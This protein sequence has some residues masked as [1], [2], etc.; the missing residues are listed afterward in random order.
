M[1]PI[2]SPFQ[3]AFLAF[4][5]N[6]SMNLMSSGIAPV[7]IARQPHHLPG[8]PGDRQL[9]GALHAAVRIAADRARRAAKRRQ[10]AG[11]Q[12]LGRRVLGIRMG[13]RR[14]RLGIERAG[15]RRIDRG[16][17]AP[18]IET[19]TL[20]QR[21]TDSGSESNQ[22]SAKQDGHHLVSA[23]A[24]APG[25]HLPR[26]SRFRPIRNCAGTAPVGCR[27][28]VALSSAEQIGI[29]VIFGQ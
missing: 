5:P 21:R 22:Q 10:L 7:A 17:G 3:P 12:F 19:R 2:N 18:G 4:A 29:A 26:C 15:R 27:E 1:S 6:R 14:Q 13:E 24:L 11:E 25:E 8:R 16:R 28:S 9:L 20:R 23:A